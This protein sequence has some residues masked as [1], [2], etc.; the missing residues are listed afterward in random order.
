MTEM[1]QRWQPTTIAILDGDTIVGNAL[2]LLLGGFGY[3]AKTLEESPA[4]R[5][6][7][8][9]DGVDL[10]LVAP[11][12]SAGPRRTFLGAMRA[13]SR[14]AK[15]PVLALSSAVTGEEGLDDGSASATW[16]NGIE[17]LADE[18]E[19]ALRAASDDGATPSSPVPYHHVVH[20][21]KLEGKDG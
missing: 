17:K 9:L 2:A 5:P 7:D 3:D 20:R 10:L 6:E 1:R 11:G 13:T 19:A 8:L 18:I 21:Q 4:G 12:V 16:P 15:M 14:T